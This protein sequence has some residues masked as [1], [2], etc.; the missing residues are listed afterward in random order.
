M[1]KDRV[2]VLVDEVPSRLALFNAALHVKQAIEGDQLVRI[3]NRRMWNHVRLHVF[4][5]FRQIC[6]HLPAGDRQRE[7]RQN[8]CEE[9]AVTLL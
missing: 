9:F 8:F 4:R 5:Q 3:W 7:T 2:G 6:R 1:L